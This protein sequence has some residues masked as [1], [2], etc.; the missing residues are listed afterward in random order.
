MN[1][2]AKFTNGNWKLPAHARGVHTP[3]ED[4]R[5]PPGEQGMIAGNRKT[6]V[7]VDPS[8]PEKGWALK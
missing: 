1:D 5:V 7:L 6:I 4:V 8:Q 3:V 2:H